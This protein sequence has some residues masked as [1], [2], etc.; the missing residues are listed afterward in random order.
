MHKTSFRRF[1][2]HIARKSKTLVAVDFMENF[3]RRNEEIN[4]HL[5]NITFLQADVTY[6]DYPTERLFLN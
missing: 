3:V 1:T 2:G 5:K 6:L 4:G